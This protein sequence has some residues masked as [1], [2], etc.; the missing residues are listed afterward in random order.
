[1]IFPVKINVRDYKAN[2]IIKIIRQ[3]KDLTQDEFAKALNISRSAL[4]MY[5]YGTVN[6]PFET[7]IKI[8]KKYNLDIIIKDKETK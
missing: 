4:Q 8:A 3:N 1:M 6:Y 7:L 2:D 5:E